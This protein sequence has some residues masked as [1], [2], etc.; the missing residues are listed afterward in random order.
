MKPFNFHGMVGCSKGMADVIT[1]IKTI[2]DADCTVLLV[3]ESG[4]GKEI[5]A[6]A[7]HDLS[8]RKIKP[9]MVINCTTIVGTLMES[10]LFGHER[11]CFT[12]AHERKSGKFEMAHEGTA[13]LDEISE[14]P[15]PLQPKL[16]R[17][18]QEKEFTRIGGIKPKSADIRIIAATNRD[19]QSMVAEGAFREDLYY[20]LK[21]VQIQIPPLRKRP[22]DIPV[23]AEHFLKKYAQRYQRPAR[24]IHRDAMSLLLSF[25]WPGNV[26]DLEHVIE[27]AVV[28]CE[29]EVI[30]GEDISFAEDLS[31]LEA[32]SWN[33]Q[34][35][36]E[37]FHRNFLA[38]A[39]TV[40]KGSKPDAANLMGITTSHLYRL[41][42]KYK[43]NNQ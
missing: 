28:M 22:D 2:A 34:T 42:K 5:I 7:I 24:S 30:H 13:F 29:T 20:R 41:I 6:R 35:A 43:P 12:G 39:L 4:T 27:R 15:L 31:M 3:G 21:V 10:E 37:D 14:L 40:T 16:L 23:L 26:R 19:I 17:I 38:R 32:G 11:G 1:T 25:P 8:R 9:F 33:Y 36:I 18:I